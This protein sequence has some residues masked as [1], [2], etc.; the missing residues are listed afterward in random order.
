MSEAARGEA[1]C[2]T[3]QPAAG[4]AQVTECMDMSIQ[5]GEVQEEEAGL[6]GC[7]LRVF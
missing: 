1:D 2:A 5:T 7:M 4:A 6:R 3:S